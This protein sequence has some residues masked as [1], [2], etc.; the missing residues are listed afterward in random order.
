[1]DHLQKEV[2]FEPASALFGGD[3]GLDFYRRIAN[4]YQSHLKPGGTLLLEIGST[5]SESVSKLFRQSV[6]VLNDLGGN[7]RVLIIENI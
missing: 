3:D 7:P 6:R 1:M 4:E 2:T 5:Q